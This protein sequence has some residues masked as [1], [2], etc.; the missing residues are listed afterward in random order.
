M[1]PLA[2]LFPHGWGEVEKAAQQASL[3]K[4]ETSLSS[5][6]CFAES[7]V[8]GF[9][10]T[11]HIQNQASEIRTLPAGSFRETAGQGADLRAVQVS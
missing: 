7:P 3:W 10:V 8:T 1:R 5:P 9:M 6:W 4:A 2:L 11:V